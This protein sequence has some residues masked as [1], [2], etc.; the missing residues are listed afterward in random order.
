MRAYLL[1]HAWPKRNP[2]VI[3]Q[4]AYPAS[5]PNVIG[6]GGTTLNAIDAA[7]DYESESGWGHGTSS[8][9]EGG[10]G[11]GISK[12]TPQPAYQA[13]VVTQSTA[14]RTAPDVSEWTPIRTPGVPVYDTYTILAAGTPWAQYG[15]HQPVPRRCFRRRRSCHRQ[16]GA[17][18]LKPICMG[19]ARRARAD[20]LAETLRPVRRHARCDERQQFLRGRT[21]LRPRHRTRHPD[22]ES[23]L[24]NDLASSP[25]PTIERLHGPTPRTQR[26][27]RR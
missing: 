10:S 15:G 19:T 20:D 3:G 12:V 27:A 8:Y 4:T 24:D 26:P 6:V 16:S 14:A 7:G 5:S 22:D 17:V 9:S 11:G 2:A 23:R 1:D 25:N 21:R 18:R 13:V